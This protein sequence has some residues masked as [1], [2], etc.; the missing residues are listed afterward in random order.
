MNRFHRLPLSALIVPLGL[1]AFATMSGG[2][3]AAPSS[4]LVFDDRFTGDIV[5]HEVRVPDDGK[6][7]YTYYETLGWRGRAAGYAGIQA[8]PKGHNYIFS[9]WDHDSHR[10]P[11]RAVHRGAGTSTEKFGGEGTGLKSWNFELGWDTGVWYTLVA[12]SW[13]VGDHTFHGFWTRS[14]R[15][16]KWTHLVTMDVAAKDA[17][18]EGGTDAFIEDWLHTGRNA[19]TIHLRGGWKRR[20]DG[21][22]HAFGSA[23]YSVNRRDLEEGGR[24]FNFRNAWNGGVAHD[25]DGPLYFMTSGGAKIAP[26]T[27]NPSNHSIARDERCPGLARGVIRSARATRSGERTLAIRWEPDPKALPPFAVTL[28]ALRPDG[29][30]KPLASFTVEAPHARSV[31]WP[32]PDTVNPQAFRLVLRCR[33]VL[34]NE[35]APLVVPITD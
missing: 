16:G 21:S 28:Q 1:G 13:P 24:S 31:E 34:D 26:T 15:T 25:V 27:E 14:G 32:L 4:H 10:A 35:V 2:Q 11:I 17:F 6:A 33:D 20:L 29:R 7:L 23:R 9:I 3:D 8:H 12:R 5:I 19:R 22:W 30:G 18:Y